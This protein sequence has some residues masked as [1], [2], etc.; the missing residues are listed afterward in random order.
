M[1]VPACRTACPP[2]DASKWPAAARQVFESWS[3]K[4]VHG[5]PPTHEPKSRYVLVSCEINL[6]ID[7]QVD[8]LSS[9]WVIVI[10]R[11]LRRNWRRRAGAPAA[12]GQATARRRGNCPRLQEGQPLERF[13]PDCRICGDPFLGRPAVSSCG[14]PPRKYPLIGPIICA[15]FV[16]VLRRQFVNSMLSV[17]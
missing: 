12:R 1:H 14:P 3:R 13:R 7:T 6:L 9:P 4:C 10:T 11:P 5:E 2:A 16:F 17:V 15:Q 8:R